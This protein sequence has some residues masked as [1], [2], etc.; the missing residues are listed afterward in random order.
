MERNIQFYCY[1]CGTPWEEQAMICTACGGTDRAQ[2]QARPTITVEHEVEHFEFPWNDLGWPLQGSVVLYG[3]P[4]SGKSS[5]SSKIRPT[6]WISKEMDPKPLSQ[7]L[8]RVCPGPMPAIWMVQNA[9][10]V[11]RVLGQITKGPLVLD[12]LTS[13]GQ[14]DALLAAHMLT[15]WCK[16]YNDRVLAILQVNKSG[17]GA[18]YMQIPHLFDTVVEL[19]KD[20]MGLRLMNV[21]KSRW[22]GLSSKYWTFDKAGQIVIPKFQAAY[23]VE[24]TPG[25]YWLH[26]YPMSGARWSG[27]L[28]MLADAGKLTPGSCSAA[29]AAA[30]MPT[31]FVE[32]SDV[33]ERRDFAVRHG[34]AWIDPETAS[35]ALREEDP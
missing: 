23:S 25:E 5:I 2:E 6:N 34:L 12:S 9:K 32:P 31:G 7:M 28:E 24:G 26:P 16:H 17:E 13:L 4:G 15:D 27:L 30:Y 11:G 19:A 3:G 22:S 14:Q 8:R 21:P 20:T 33:N 18:G 10:D 1:R 29:M 35:V